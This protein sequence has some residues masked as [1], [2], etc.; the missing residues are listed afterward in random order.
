M[1]DSI[2]KNTT[3]QHS[4]VHTLE[5]PNISERWVNLYNAAFA[6]TFLPNIHT[7]QRAWT[8]QI[9]QPKTLPQQWLCLLRIRIA[10]HICDWY[11]DSLELCSIDSLTMQDLSSLPPQLVQ[12][13]VQS[14]SA[15]ILQKLTHTTGYA[16]EFV[17]C[18]VALP[19]HAS[20][21]IFLQAKNQP[22]L[23][24]TFKN[25]DTSS[26]VHGYLTN[27]PLELVDICADI[28]MQKTAQLTEHQ[29]SELA[30]ELTHERAEHIFSIT[31]THITLPIIWQS[32]PMPLQEIQNLA[33]GDCLLL[34]A[35][36]PYIHVRV[37]VPQS[38]RYTHA[39]INL[40][41]KE[42]LLESYM[43][44]DMYEHQ[45][46]DDE[47]TNEAYDTLDENSQTA[48]YVDP[49]Q[50]PIPVH[51]QLGSVSLSIDAISKLSPGM[52]LGP[53]ESLEAPVTIC[54]GKSTIGRG[55]LVNIE[56]RIGVQITDIFKK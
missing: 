16:F 41:T 40:S 21:E 19:A 11:M 14:T 33:P 4:K 38:T 18:T 9:T 49:L 22:G 12:I 7:H 47:Y 24:F 42:I 5:L 13:I 53:L 23:G 17:D 25:T 30:S 20:T 52:I 45:K 55:S 2:L 50:C 44:D 31:H 54:V 46:N 27:F 1:E 26:T 10:G 39:Q 34:P 56:G 29:A 8:C 48:S 15:D 37:Y 32:T 43:Q 51:C 3:W 35:Q 28:F 6:N 36:E